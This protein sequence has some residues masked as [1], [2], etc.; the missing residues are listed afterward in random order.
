MYASTREANL[1]TW[2]IGAEEE[3]VTDKE[4]V[5]LTLKTWPDRQPARKISSLVFEPMMYDLQNKHCK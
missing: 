5:A 3:V 2:I 4:G 1:P